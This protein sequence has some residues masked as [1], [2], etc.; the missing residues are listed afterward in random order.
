[1]EDDTKECIINVFMVDLHTDEFQI[2]LK[3]KIDSS[4]FRLALPPTD[5]YHSSLST[6]EQTYK[7]TMSSCGN[8]ESDSVQ[9]TLTQTDF[10]H[11]YKEIG[12]GSLRWQVLRN[13]PWTLIIEV[14]FK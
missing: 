4:F 10:V 1:M 5:Q 12:P 14:H 9:L 3:R 13:I 2:L 8:K 11:V 7:R 6:D